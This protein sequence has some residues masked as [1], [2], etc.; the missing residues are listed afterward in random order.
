MAEA[1]HQ[2][3]LDLSDAAL[4]RRFAMDDTD[5]EGL[6]AYAL[7]RQALISFRQDFT[8]QTGAP[9]SQEAEQAFLIG[10]I[11][12]ARIATYREQASRLIGHPA[13][14]P[15]VAPAPG[16]KKPRRRWVA[17]FDGPPVLM[18]DQPD[19]VNWKG[20]LYRLAVLLLAVV[21]TA[22]LLRVLFT[23]PN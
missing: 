15:K 3:P 5:A 12:S 23:R 18:P 1:A 10:E 16:P 14:A 13:P 20:L 17:L 21:V 19:K 4:L 6:L 8:R 7:H 2:L 11:A 9:P 22:L